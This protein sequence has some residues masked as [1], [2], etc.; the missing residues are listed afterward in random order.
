MTSAVDWALNNN[1][2]YIYLVTIEWFCDIIF[3]ITSIQ[4]CS[5]SSIRRSGNSLDFLTLFQKNKW[6]C[7]CLASTSVQCK[8]SSTNITL[9]ITNIHVWCN[10]RKLICSMKYR[11]LII[12]CSLFWGENQTQTGIGWERKLGLTAKVSNLSHV[13]VRILLLESYHSCS[14]S[15]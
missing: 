9:L 10:D 6:H 14:I 7:F 1:Y 4:M 2:L 5:F 11:S 13:P 15:Q 8:H 12:D 3:G